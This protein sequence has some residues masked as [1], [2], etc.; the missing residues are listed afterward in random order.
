MR[1]LHRLFGGHDTVRCVSLN[2]DTRTTAVFLW[3]C[4]H[5]V[6]NEG[7]PVPHLPNGHS[8]YSIWVEDDAWCVNVSQGRVCGWSDKPIHSTVVSDTGRPRSFMAKGLVWR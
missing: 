7:D 2:G 4:D 5:T 3:N 8:T 6:Y 1:W